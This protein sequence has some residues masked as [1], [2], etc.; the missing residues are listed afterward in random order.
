MLQ[1][2]NIEVFCLHPG[3]IAGGL[4]WHMGPLKYA[5]IYGLYF[6]SKS[7]EQVWHGPAAMLMLYSQSLLGC[8]SRALLLQVHAHVSE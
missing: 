7:A 1:G 5:I 6:L 4:S 8:C 3:I 2:S